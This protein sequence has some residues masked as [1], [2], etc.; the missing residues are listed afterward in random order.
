MRV[1]ILTGGIFHDFGQMTAA[2]AGILATAGMEMEL[3]GSPAELVAAL[4]SAPADVVVV[5]ALRFRMLGN[6]KY[7]PYTEQW[8]YETQP[9]LVRALEAHA[10]AGGGIVALHTGCICFDDWQGWH[11]LLAGGW[12]WGQSY[13]AP[14]LESVDVTPLGDHPVTEGIAPF[15]VIDEHYRD[16]AIHPEAIILAQGR[17]R[18]GVDYPVAW[19]RDRGDGGPRAVTLTIGHDLTS[20][21]NPE[22]ARF[23][24][25][26]ALWVAGKNGNNN[27]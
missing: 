25:Q 18:E 22:Q 19:A 1:V 23:I 11:D 14:G 3:V 9:D 10:G 26:A 24:Q 2:T 8:A 27:R 16:L 6:E 17:T 20:I 7:A 21:A 13:H 4:D 5:Q 15:C 12:V